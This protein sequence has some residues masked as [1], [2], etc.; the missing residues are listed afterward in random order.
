MKRLK[1]LV[2][3]LFALGLVLGPMSASA[4]VFTPETKSTAAL[5]ID[6]NTGRVLADK[7][8]NERLP[9]G[10]VSKLVVAYFIE[11]AVAKGELSWDQKIKIKPKFV[12][13]SHD[14]SV[15]TVPLE[16]DGEYT[17]YD[18]M[19]ATLIPSSNSAS[20]VLADLIAGDQEKFNNMADEKLASWGIKDAKWSSASG[21]PVGALGPFQT[22]TYHEDDMN[23][24]SA[25]EVAIIAGRLLQDYPHVLKFNGTVSTEFPDGKGGTVTLKNTNELLQD[26][27]YE[28]EG[29]KT[30][31]ILEYGKNLVVK[32]K[33]HGVPVLS[34]LLNA[35]PGDSETELFVSSKNMWN[36]ATE[37]LVA[38]T[39]DAG[40]SL[41]EV[42]EKS[43]DVGVVKTGLSDAHTYLLGKNEEKPSFT[44]VKL[45]TEAPITAGQKIG[46]ATWDFT[47]E[48]D[49]F[50]PDVGTVDVSSP[51]DVNKAN[52]FVRTWRAIFN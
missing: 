16:A 20:L 33:I 42:K 39:M 40:Y 14:L 5:L 35:K 24:L 34:V 13:Y 10:S 31:T 38:E 30:G 50:L 8:S 52:W 26:T 7:N 47:G 2:V 18:L 27:D 28:V 3:S 48:P 4:A 17:L 22:D 9:L 51:E 11:E 23:R 36:Q 41:G 1:K 45:N 32:T 12:E 49:F 21:L 43:A 15:A 19:N 37:A 25:R 44:D 46:T 29:M 6:L